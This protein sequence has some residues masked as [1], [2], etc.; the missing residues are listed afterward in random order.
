MS[1]VSPTTLTSGAPSSARRITSLADLAPVV[2]DL[3]LVRLDGSVVTLPVKMPTLRDALL[4]DTADAEPTPP[5]MGV[6]PDTKTP[7]YDY[8]NPQYKAAKIDVYIT[9]QYRAALS[10][11]A[12]PV[13]G[14]TFEAK[15]AALDAVLDSTEV[16]Q[17]AL[18][19]RAVT[20]SGE[21]H[22]L[23]RAKT[24]Q[25]GG[26]AAPAHDGAVPPE[27]GGAPEPAG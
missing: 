27:P 15:R 9:R 3:E 13:A 26:L 6:N 20:K 4:V 25:R 17:L 8:Q 10:I 18:F 5:T 12:F 14:D 22:V 21:E 19:F 11:L 1:T 2:I 7:L 16:G 23:A 24:F